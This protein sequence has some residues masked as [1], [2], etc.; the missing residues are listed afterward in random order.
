MF[1]YCQFSK[2]QMKVLTWWQEGSPYKDY[3][4]IIAEG[5]IRSGKTLLLSL[6]FVIWSLENYNQNQFAICGKT[7]QSLR[8][9]VITPL[10]ER[11]K[12]RGY[13]VKEK[14]TDN[15][16]YISKGKKYNIY[17][18]FG[19]KD[20]SSQN[21]IQGITLS[22]ILFDET[23]LMPESFVNQAMARC[24]VEGSKYWFN[25]NPEGPF[26]W[27][28]TNQIDKA[29]EKKYLVLKFRLEDNLSL[30]DE[31]VNRY[32][33]MYTGLFYKRYILGEWALAEGTI[34]DC[35]DVN[36]NTYEVLPDIIRQKEI[37]PVYGADYGINNPMVYL[38]IYVFRDTMSSNYIGSPNIYNVYVDDEYY[39]DGKNSLKQ[40]SDDEYVQDFKKFSNCDVD[41]YR[42]IIID[43]TASSL[44]VS[45]RKAGILTQKAK[46][47]KNMYDTKEDSVLSGIRLVYELMNSGR[48]KINK[49]CTNLLQ[50]IVS[51]SWDPKA[52][53]NGK[54]KPIKQNDHCLD[55]LRYVIYT[56]L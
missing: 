33:S 28:K 52:S 19:G 8:R 39:Y 21:L 20:E 45:L 30:T 11:L 6:S 26:H 36:K 17:Y 15:C 24:S 44:I 12:D 56:L 48:L 46:R 2:N 42:S 47:V 3:N 5:S 43:P 54:E 13:K 38:K 41:Y 22:G 27:F 35:F 40:K 31:I 25:C 4:G 53:E 49:R 16:L 55:A 32:K 7:I 50:E 34:Y 18:L 51:Y 10:K 23:A 29:E 1:K 9:N 37:I 14:V